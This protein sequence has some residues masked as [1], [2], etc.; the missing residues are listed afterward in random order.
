MT[1]FGCSLDPGLNWK[2]SNN[3]YNYWFIAGMMDS[4]VQ[5]EF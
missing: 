5:K 3:E 2:Q 1:E 4:E